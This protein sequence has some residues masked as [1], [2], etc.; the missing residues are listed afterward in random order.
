MNCADC[1]TGPMMPEHIWLEYAGFA[2]PKRERSGE[3]GSSLIDRRPT[4]RGICGSCA[5]KRQ[6]GIAPAQS[7]LGI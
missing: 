2:R 1:G 7:G 5:T 3:S 6:H 4:G